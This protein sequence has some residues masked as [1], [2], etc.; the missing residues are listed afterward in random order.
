MP[1]ARYHVAAPPAGR[2]LLLFDGE[3]R[4]C[5]RW[6]G[7][8]RTVFAGRL[9]VAP[10]QEA[11]GRFPEIPVAAYDEALQLI[12]P[13]GAVYSGACAALRARAHGRARRGWL[14]PVYEAVPGAPV[15]MELGYRIVARNR[16]IFSMLMG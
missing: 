12:E 10:S 8:W 15:L 6:A 13:D 16:R 4:F 1:F 3:C 5:Q 2:P 9:D 11:R 14:L 7:H